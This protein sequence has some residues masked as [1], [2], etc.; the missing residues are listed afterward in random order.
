LAADSVAAV[1][2]EACPA[3]PAAEVTGPQESRISGTR[4]SRYDLRCTVRGEVMT[5]SY[6]VAFAGNRAWIVTLGGRGTVQD[7]DYTDYLFRILDTV[8]LR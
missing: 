8:R 7:A 3:D 1:R 6:L 5:L 4:F 2:Q